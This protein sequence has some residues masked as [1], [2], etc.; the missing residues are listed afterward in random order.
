M[1]RCVDTKFHIF[2]ISITSKCNLICGH[3]FRSAINSDLSLS[4]I[5]NILES[6]SEF[7]YF[8]ILGGGEPLLHSNFFQI[9]YL[10][11]NK[12][13]PYSISTNASLL[14]NSNIV[15]IK[16]YRPSYIQVSMDKFHNKSRETEQCV[17]KLIRARIKTIIASVLEDNY[18]NIININEFC[19]NNG[20][21]CHRIIRLKKKNSKELA[22][23]IKIIIK[24]LDKNITE[25]DEAYPFLITNKKRK[26]AIG[27][28]FSISN[29]RNVYC[30]PFTE[31]SRFKIGTIYELPD[32]IKKFKVSKFFPKNNICSITCKNYH[33]CFGGCELMKYLNNDQNCDPLCASK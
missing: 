12:K 20:V 7:K 2:Q 27:N 19:K 24:H 16:K 5:R 25:V 14:T 33:K 22:G 11:K 13:V 8:L 9:L 26:C 18:N 32:C 29:N 28:T 17:K 31:N 10:I 15:K 4:E 6:L 21:S 1:F 23:N 3:C 30:C